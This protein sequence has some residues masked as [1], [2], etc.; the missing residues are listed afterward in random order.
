MN[1]DA[2]VP[3]AAPMTY[4]FKPTTVIMRQS[5]FTPGLARAKT[6]CILTSRCMIDEVAQ[7][8]AADRPPAAAAA[9]AHPK[10]REGAGPAR[11]AALCIGTRLPSGELPRSSPRSVLRRDRWRRHLG[12]A[13]EREK[14]LMAIAVVLYVIFCLLAGL[15]GSQ[16]RM[17][18]FGTFLLSLVITPLLV[19][20][21][22]IFTRASRGERDSSPQ[23]S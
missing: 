11:R 13:L 5:R 17:G 9:V 4:S 22:L 6:C 7:L 19:L 8:A 12:T 1:W 15:A 18:F 3:R 14:W 16:R 10:S 23:S 20:L 21:L 2:L